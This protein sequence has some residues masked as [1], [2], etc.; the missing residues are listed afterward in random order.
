[1]QHG[2]CLNDWATKVSFSHY[3]TI[4]L[5][6]SNEKITGWFLFDKLEVCI[7]NCSNV[8]SGLVQK[9]FHAK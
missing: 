4:C 2:K 3:H 6:T 9:H 5:D 8:G 7:Q 1:M